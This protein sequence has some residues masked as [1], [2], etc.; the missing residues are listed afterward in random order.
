MTD[1]VEGAAGVKTVRGAKVERKCKGC[2]RS[3]LARVADVKRGWGRFCS[4]S[5]KA[6]V[7]E[8]NTGQ[9]AKHLHGSQPD[10][11]DTAIDAAFH[12]FSS[13]GLGQW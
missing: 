8:A 12:P 6:K 11:H 7:Q 10:D 9:Y 2:G 5:C 1:K 3:F 13:E 4:K